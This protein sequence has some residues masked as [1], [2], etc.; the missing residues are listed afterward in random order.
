MFAH[1][2]AR[3]T[4]LFAKFCQVS[5]PHVR[6]SYT[7]GLPPYLPSFVKLGGYEKVARNAAAAKAESLVGSDSGFLPQVASQSFKLS[8]AV[9]VPVG[10]PDSVDVP[11]ASAEDFF[12]QAV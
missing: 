4:R 9:A 11:A 8:F 12:A 3:I 1:Q 6:A 10:G 2:N 5:I 7:H